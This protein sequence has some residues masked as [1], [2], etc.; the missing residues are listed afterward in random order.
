MIVIGASTLQYLQARQYFWDHI[1][2]KIPDDDLN[3]PANFAR[4]LESQGITIIKARPDKNFATDI[5]GIA[6]GWDNLV[7]AD[8]DQAVLFY[9]KWS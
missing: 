5:F 2:P 9:L 4:W 1:L 3:W 6:P 8:P 7:F